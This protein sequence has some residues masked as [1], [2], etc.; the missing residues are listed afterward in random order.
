MCNSVFY[1][2]SCVGRSLGLDFA[3]VIFAMAQRTD[4]KFKC[5][6]A[7]TN[8]FEATGKMAPNL[9]YLIRYTKII[10][11][12]HVSTPA[13]IN[14]AHHKLA[15]SRPHKKGTQI[16][17]FW[18]ATFLIRIF[19]FFLAAEKPPPTFKQYSTG[20]HFYDKAVV[21]RIC[22][23]QLRSLELHKERGIG[24][25]ERKQMVVRKLHKIGGWIREGR[26]KDRFYVAPDTPLPEYLL[27]PKKSKKKESVLSLDFQ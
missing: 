8:A 10:P 6:N 3:F 11:R 20:L 1:V 19:E 7:E 27:P 17:K 26:N 9:P 16:W 5:T 21:K 12:Q 25:K 2:I 13:E 24:N 4:F 23:D 14:E 15:A 22:C 18:S